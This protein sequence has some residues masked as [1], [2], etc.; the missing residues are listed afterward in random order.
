MNHHQ[1]S[2][3][4]HL[5]LLTS[6][7]KSGFTVSITLGAIASHAIL[8]GEVLP[9]KCSPSGWR[10]HSHTAGAGAGAEAEA[11][12]VGGGG[13]RPVLAAAGAASVDSTCPPSRTAG[14][15]AKPK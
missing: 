8:F 7:L 14:A 3:V 12:G 6:L 4:V 2:I 10:P 5:T 13:W 15:E 11:V 1:S 9:A